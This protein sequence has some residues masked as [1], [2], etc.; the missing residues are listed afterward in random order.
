MSKVQEIME[1][2]GDQVSIF[3]LNELI[4]KFI[5]LNQVC[6]LILDNL[7]PSKFDFV[8]QEDLEELFF[9]FAQM[10]ITSILQKFNFDKQQYF[11]YMCSK[12]KSLTFYEI[13]Q[14]LAHN[15]NV[16]F[17]THEQ[18]TLR[19][20]FLPNYRNEDISQSKDRKVTLETF[21]IMFLTE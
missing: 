8:K 2:G 1:V 3:D 17:S 16:Y 13:F 20:Q 7:R 10:K 9:E 19:N 15:F 21:E 12:R 4:G 5:P 11:D 6:M 18:I 14:C